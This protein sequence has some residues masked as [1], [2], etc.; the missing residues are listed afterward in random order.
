MEDRQGALQLCS[1]ARPRGL[2]SADGA[3]GLSV[4]RRAIAHKLQNPASAASTPAVGSKRKK[5]AGFERASFFDYFQET[6][7]QLNADLVQLLFEDFWRRAFDYYEGVRNSVPGARQACAQQVLIWNGV[8]VAQAGG[9]RGQ[10]EEG[11]DTLGAV[12]DQDLKYVGDD[13]VDDD[14]DDEDSEDNE[15]A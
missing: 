5:E 1:V 8:V 12:Q 2:S 9:C 3:W 11:D 10:V 13:D 15:D 14:E 6:N 7:Q 4:G